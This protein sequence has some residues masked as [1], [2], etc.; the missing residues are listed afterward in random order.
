MLLET[1]VTRSR[2]ADR[3]N[4]DD[5]ADGYDDEVKDERHPIRA[6]Y[7]A[8]LD[9]VAEGARG[10]VLDLGVGTGNLAARLP[11]GCQVTGVDIS[12]R[13]LSLARAKLPDADLVRDDLLAYA[14]DAPGPWDTVV[15]TYALHHLEDDEKEALLRVLAAKLTPGG[16]IAVGDLMFADAA[17]R[18]A[19]CEERPPLRDAVAEEYFWL[20]DRAR[21]WF[22]G[23][24]EVERF[25]A[26]SWG[27]RT[28]R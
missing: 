6:G 19:L 3:F 11:G 12:A 14:H 27:I 4:H 8:V 1:G 7:G 28:P 21:G 13:M 9:W 24:V 22:D 17:E 20:V 16:R 25:S 26:L 5:D 10:N 23:P 15:S 18:D 2:H